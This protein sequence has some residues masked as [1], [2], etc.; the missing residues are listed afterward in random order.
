MRQ[1]GQ[2]LQFL[3]VTYVDVKVVLNKWMFY[4]TN[5]NTVNKATQCIV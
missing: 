1:V 4:V 5:C 3:K 2:I